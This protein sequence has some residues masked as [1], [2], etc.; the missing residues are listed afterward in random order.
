MD[1]QFIKYL[2]TLQLDVNA[3][4]NDI[5]KAY[6]KL[7]KIHHPDLFNKPENKEKASK[8]FKIITTAYE[9]LLNNYIPPEERTYI[10][11]NK[12]SSE[13][14]EW[15][16]EKDLKNMLLMFIKNETIIQMIYFDDYSYKNTSIIYIIPL[17]VLSVNFIAYSISENKENIYQLDRVYSLKVYKGNVDNIKPKRKSNKYRMENYSD[18]PKDF[19]EYIIKYFPILILLSLLLVIF[20]FVFV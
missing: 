13:N 20:S 16:F 4:K 15:N 18:L 12:N 8:N 1:N 10:I 14:I 17:E 19:S 5:K 2:K 6:R 7:V 9:Y 3:N 11:S